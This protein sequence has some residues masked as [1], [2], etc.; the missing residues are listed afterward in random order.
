M[1][2]ILFVAFIVGGCGPSVSYST[3]GAKRV[4]Q[5]GGA[6]VAA[7]QIMDGRDKGAPSASPILFGNERHRD[8]EEL[9]KS[10]R[11]HA[12]RAGFAQE[13]GWLPPAPN[14]PEEAEAVM[15]EAVNRGIDT[16][17]FTRLNMVTAGGQ[18]ATVVSVFTVLNYLAVLGVGF[19]TLV[20]SVIVFSLPINEEHVV[21]NVTGYLVEPRGRSVLASFSEESVLSDDSVTAWGHNPPAEVAD[22]IFQALEKVF[23]RAG[24]LINDGKLLPGAAGD[25]AIKLFEAPELPV[26]PPDPTVVP[27]EV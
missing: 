27:A 19:A 6:K 20:P 7:V 13:G 12:H 10:M 8:F 26:P 1:R 11:E 2:S 17:L 24:Q 16:L 9:R 23:Q 22:H 25:A 14:T 5:G 15:A 18:V 3:G 21:V 4:L